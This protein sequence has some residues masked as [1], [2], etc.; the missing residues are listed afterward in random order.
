LQGIF[1]PFAGAFASLRAVSV[2]EYGKVRPVGSTPAEY[3]LVKE[4]VLTTKDSSSGRRMD[5][6]RSWSAFP[7]Y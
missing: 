3:G 1:A 7:G 4:H 2:N 6:S 5:D